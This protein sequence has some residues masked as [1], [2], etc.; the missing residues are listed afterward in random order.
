MES[1]LLMALSSVGMMLLSLSLAYFDNRLFPGQMMMHHA[2]K[3]FPGIA[4][5]ALWGNLMLMPFV[6]Y[7][8]GPY[9]DHGN[10][11]VARSAIILGTVLSLYA[12]LFVYRNG[13][14]DDAW[15]GKGEIHPAGIVAM[16]YSA[17]LIAAFIVFYVY[18]D[19]KRTDIWTIWYLL[20]LYFPLANHLVFDALN[21]RY[22][23]VWCPRIFAEEARPM[24][25]FAIGELFITL[26]TALK[27]AFPKPW[28]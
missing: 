28:L 20:A 9:W 13:L 27:L 23:F 5:G 26:V 8:I 17:M 21:E 6:F 14:Q 10:P 4:N 19:A 22:G 25:M 2:A 24:L 15:A 11:D 16:V 1:G 7:I 12:F 18:S 3:G